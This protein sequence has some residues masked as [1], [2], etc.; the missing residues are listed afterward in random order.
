M[1]E[2][3]APGPVAGELA[4]M[5]LAQGSRTGQNEKDVSFSK[6]PDNTVFV[7]ASKFKAQYAK[8][9]REVARTRTVIVIPRRGKPV[10]RLGPAEEAPRDP[11]IFGFARGAVAIHG[12]IV[13]PLDEAWEALE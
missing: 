6:R 1:Q 11:D 13:A 4:K 9:L 10:A 2:A 7:P 5:N 3:N 12:D 8:L